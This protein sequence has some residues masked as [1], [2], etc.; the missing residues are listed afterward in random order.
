MK[1]ILILLIFLVLSI[2]SYCQSYLGLTTK[3]VNLREGP[4]TEYV[5]IS[6]LPRGTQL[7]IISLETEYDFYNV[8]DIE[9][10][11]TGYIHKSFVEVG[12]ELP[13]N[14]EG[15]FTQSAET[16]TYNPEIEIYNK[17]EK[18]LT[19]VMNSETYIFTPYERK[20]LTLTPGKYEYRASAPSVIPDY[21]SEYLKNNILYSW[22]FF[23]TTVRR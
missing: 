15:I 8:I 12:E 23:I 22:E 20:K 17:T 1:K 18:T 21:G 16:E 5:V 9:T 10:N 7:F 13:K 6:S 19:L 3:Q 14:Q 4:G 11:F 2:S